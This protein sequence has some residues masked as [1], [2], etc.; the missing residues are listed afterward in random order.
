MNEPIFTIELPGGIQNIQ[1]DSFLVEL[2]TGAQGIKGDTGEQGPANTLSI[3]SVEE[4]EKASAIITGESPHQLLSLVLPKGDPGE[5]GIQGEKGDMGPK[6]DKGDPGNDFTVIGTVNSI[7]ELPNIDSVKEGTS[8][9]VGDSI[10]R[11]VYTADKVKGEWINQGPLQGP[12]GDVGP[13]G[14]TGQNGSDGQNGITPHIGE[15]GNWFLGAS[16]TGNP[17]QGPQG[18]Q[19]NKGKDG[20]GITNV[21]SET[22]IQEDGY[23]IT[24][25]IFNKS[26]GF[27]NTVN[28]K[29]KNGTGIPTGGEIGQVLAKASENDGDVKWVNQTGKNPDY[30]SAPLGSIFGYPSLSAPTGYMICDGRE[31][32]RTDYA[33]LFEVI[34]TSYGEGDGSTTFNLPNLKGRSIVGHDADDTDFNTLSKNGGSKS[35]TQTIDEMPKHRLEIGKRTGSTGSGGYKGLFQTNNDSNEAIYTQYIGSDKPMDIMNPYIVACYIIKV[36]GTTILK[37]N[38]VDS[39]DDNSTTN[40]P[41]QRAVNK[42][43]NNKSYLIA[44]LSNSQS[45]NLGLQLVKFDTESKVGDCFKL[46]NKTNKIEVLQDCVVLLS[47]SIF[48]DG[49]NGD[50]YVWA[51]IRV[52]SENITSNLTRVINRDYT[53]CSIPTI[54]TQLKINDVIDCHVDY[55]LA[56]GTPKIRVSNDNTFLSVVK[57]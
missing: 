39:L 55:S 40:A 53:Q 20:V 36:S 3:G 57:I 37:G 32:N 31:L 2:P 14:P 43:L 21:V 26:D 35:H 16:D 45:I 13:Q 51:H 17:S 38:V 11:D 44:T 41:S 7:S 19:G 27:S 47:G 1:G 33:P 12:K 9:F 34:G 23:T 8:Y 15:N 54:A 56:G 24:P 22:D 42:A 28:V 4:G 48:V 46:N 29:A 30:D 25:I 18:I 5:Q 49:S 10:P 52:N 6:G 50:G